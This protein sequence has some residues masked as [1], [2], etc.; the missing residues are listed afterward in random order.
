MLRLTNVRDVGTSKFSHR[1]SDAN[2]S[3]LMIYQIEE[4]R[5]HPFYH[6][7]LMTK[8]YLS[9]K[10]ENLQKILHTRYYNS[11]TL[12]QIEPSNF[13]YS[14]HDM[15]RQK[16]K[17]WNLNLASEADKKSQNILNP[18]YSSD[19]Q[20]PQLLGLEQHKALFPRYSRRSTDTKVMSLIH[21]HDLTFKS[22]KHSA[23]LST[24][25]LC[26][27]CESK[28]DTNFHQ[29]LQCPRFNCSYRK[30]LLD[31]HGP[32]CVASLVF[33]S[34]DMNQLSCLRKMSQ[35]ILK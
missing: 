5:S 12:I 6:H 35:I 4:C 24:S 7:I 19:A 15:D 23:K 26:Q 14:K 10:F 20:A 29:L 22:F 17:L 13:L 33:T 31:F 34:Y 27:T 18:C 32:T 8:D 1:A 9:S 16:L 30:S 25:P 21:G 3:G 11:S 28:K 2:M